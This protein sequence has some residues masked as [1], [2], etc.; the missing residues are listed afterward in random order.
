MHA[1]SYFLK[2]VKVGCYVQCW[3]LRSQT[4]QFGR[5]SPGALRECFQDTGIYLG[6]IFIKGKSEG[7]SALIPRGSFPV[8]PLPS[9]VPNDGDKAHSNHCGKQKSINARKIERFLSVVEN[10]CIVGLSGEMAKEFGCAPAHDHPTS[11][12]WTSQAPQPA[13]RRWVRGR[14][15]NFEYIVA[16]FS[17]RCPPG[18]HPSIIGSIGR[19]VPRP[20]T[21]LHF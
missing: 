16:N 3:Y 10:H 15:K 21:H 1:L 13:Q 14:P 19:H 17:S 5:L 20:R 18:P 9:F 7:G 4:R 8:V 12:A 6:L 2:T 11:L